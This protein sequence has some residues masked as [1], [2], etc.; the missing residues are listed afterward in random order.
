MFPVACLERSQNL[1][2]LVFVFGFSTFMI[3][4]TDDIEKKN[5]V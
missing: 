2:F 1:F 4:N 3:F 5:E